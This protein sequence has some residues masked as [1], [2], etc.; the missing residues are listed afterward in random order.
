MNPVRCCPACRWETTWEGIIV[1]VGCVRC[2]H[3]APEYLMVDQGQRKVEHHGLKGYRRGCRCWRC[4]YA[5]A[6]WYRK[7]CVDRTLGRLTEGRT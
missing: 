3:P 1:W 5:R 4:K 2:E 6:A 7:R